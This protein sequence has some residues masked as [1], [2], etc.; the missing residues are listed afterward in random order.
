MRAILVR[1]GADQS[2]GGGNWN[3]PIDSRAGLFAYVPI[4][5]GKAVREGL[6]RPYTELTTLLRDFKLEVPDHLVGRDMHLDPDFEHLSYGDQ[7]QRARQIR[8]LQIDDYI[9]FYAGL[10]DVHSGK[11]VYALIG[12]LKIG[13]ILLATDVP[14]KEWGYNA[15]TRRILKVSADDLVIRGQPS[16]SGKLRRCIPIGEFRNKAYRVREDILEAWGGLSVKDG[17]LQRSAR[18]P[19]IKDLNKFLHWF[20]MQNVELV[21]NN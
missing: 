20:K 12:F 18:L 7:G 1:V 19:E 14:E 2:D 3:G 13:A 11:L 6:N 8:G 21:R 15:H 4:P 10:K 5:E 17:Y 16:E 9:V